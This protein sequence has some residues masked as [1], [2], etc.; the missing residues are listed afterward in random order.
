MYFAPK[1]ATL[2]SHQH[3]DFTNQ[4]QLGYLLKELFWLT[5]YAISVIRYIGTFLGE[6]AGN[7]CISLAI[8]SD[9]ENVITA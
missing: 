5:T 7:Q 3:R 9:A 4:K 2:E 1:N 6:S 8:Y